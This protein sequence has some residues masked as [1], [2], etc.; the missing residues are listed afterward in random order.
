MRW[1]WCSRMAS[2]FCCCHLHQYLTTQDYGI[3]SIVTSLVQFLSIFVLLSLNAAGCGI[4]TNIERTREAKDPV[5][6]CTT[7]FLNAFVIVTVVILAHEYILEPF[8]DD[9]PFYPYLFVGVLACFSNPAGIGRPISSRTKP[10]SAQVLDL[11]YFVMN[12]VLA[13]VLVAVFKL[14][15]MGVIW[16]LMATNLTFG[17]ISHFQFRS[18]IQRTIERQLK[19]AVKY[20]LPLLPHARRLDDGSRSH[21]STT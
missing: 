14:K 3:V 5:R 16:A 1:S 9:I 10:E 18:K 17:L 2:A 6:R 11:G 13:L 12:I 19:Q 4:T 7:R 8:I 15:A 20:S 21:F